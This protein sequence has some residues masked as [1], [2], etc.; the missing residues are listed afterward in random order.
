MQR[1]TEHL[2]KI[3]C[4]DFPIISNSNYRRR[5]L[6]CKLKPLENSFHKIRFLSVQKNEWQFEAIKKAMKVTSIGKIT[7]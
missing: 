2:Y 1:S 3:T 6:I 7:N 4:I 5:E